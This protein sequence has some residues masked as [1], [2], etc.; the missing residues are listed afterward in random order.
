MPYLR[1]FSVIF[2]ASCLQTLPALSLPFLFSPF[3]FFLIGV[4]QCLRQ[5]NDLP[6]R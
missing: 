4:I 5:E 3:W 6:W 2:H 1:L